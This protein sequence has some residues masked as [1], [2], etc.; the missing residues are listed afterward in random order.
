MAE[1]RNARVASLLHTVSAGAENPLERDSRAAAHRSVGCWPGET[2]V[3][4]TRTGN[5]EALLEKGAPASCRAARERAHPPR[6]SA[7]GTQ[8]GSAE[9]SLRT[10]HAGVPAMLGRASAGPATPPHAT[11]SSGLSHGCSWEEFPSF[12][13]PRGALLR[14][15]PPHPAA[16]SKGVPQPLPGPSVAGGL[17]PRLKGSVPAHRSGAGLDDLPAQT[18]P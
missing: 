15:G 12:G 14:L 18:S 7:N 2:A 11:T 6:S 8:S 17:L 10:N 9:K 5:T 13:A 16:K 4:S 1:G 3:H